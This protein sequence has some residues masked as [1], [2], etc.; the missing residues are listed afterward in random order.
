MCACM[1]TEVAFTLNRFGP[2]CRLEGEE[3]TNEPTPEEV[4]VRWIRV[5]GRGIR[6]RCGQAAMC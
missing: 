3:H 5:G 2:I 6:L 1:A 4:K